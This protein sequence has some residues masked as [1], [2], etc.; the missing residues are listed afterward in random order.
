MEEVLGEKHP[1]TAQSY[2]NV[3]YAYGNLG[4]E[5]TAL[6]YL[7]KALKIMEEVLG[8]KHPYTAQSY[9]NVGYAYIKLGDEKTALEYFSKAQGMK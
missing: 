3:G 2:N 7:L 5:K 9:N 8:E 1:Y 4:D 6:E